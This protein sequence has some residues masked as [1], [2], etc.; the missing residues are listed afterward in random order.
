MSCPGPT[1][2]VRRPDGSVSAEF[3]GSDAEANAKFSAAAADLYE[4][5]KAALV[6]LHEMDSARQRDAERRECAYMGMT[7]VR[8]AE[9]ALAKAEGQG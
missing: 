7:E 8:M 1:W 5:L 4:A 2:L 6:R 3:Y 9:A